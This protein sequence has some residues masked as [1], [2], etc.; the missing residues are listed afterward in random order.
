MFSRVDDKQCHFRFC[1]FIVQIDY[2]YQFDKSKLSII[3][4]LGHQNAGK[5]SGITP[6][7]FA[8]KIASRTI[9]IASGLGKL[10]RQANAI[11][12]LGAGGS[13]DL[14]DNMR[15]SSR[16]GTQAVQ[17]NIVSPTPEATM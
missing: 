5:S 4:P 15:F 17:G 14:K 3:V 16:V 7:N 6:F 8:F 2:I 12:L 10:L 11:L 13:N 1:F 9:E